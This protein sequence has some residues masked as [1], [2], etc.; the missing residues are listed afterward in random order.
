MPAG[1]RSVRSDLLE[2]EREN[3]CSDVLALRLDDAIGGLGEGL[4]ESALECAV[5]LPFSFMLFAFWFLLSS[6]SER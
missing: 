6:F 2:Q 4:G 3:G 5:D 1:G